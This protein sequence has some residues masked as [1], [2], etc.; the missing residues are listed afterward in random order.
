LLAVETESFLLYYIIVID[1]ITAN[2]KLDSFFKMRLVNIAF[3][4]LIV[5]SLMIVL[6]EYFFPLDY[7]QILILDMFDLCIVV[8]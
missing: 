6:I 3:G 8:A 1:N 7:Q 5:T 4:V 2:M